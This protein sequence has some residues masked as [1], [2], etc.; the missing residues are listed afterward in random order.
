MFFKYIVLP[1]FLRLEW[2]S[3]TNAWDLEVGLQYVSEGKIN[4]GI[5]YWKKS[6]QT[7][8]SRKARHLTRSFS[9]RM[10]SNTTLLNTVSFMIKTWMNKTLLKVWKHLRLSLQFN[11]INAV[12]ILLIT[13]HI[14]CLFGYNWC[15][16]L[17]LFPARPD[18]KKIG[19]PKTYTVQIKRLAGVWGEEE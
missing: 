7:L 13:C 3:Y 19:L 18:Y 12:L 6:L 14:F 8:F 17:C 16:F 1:S 4:R 11:Y 9:V 5:A 10:C 15:F 2:T